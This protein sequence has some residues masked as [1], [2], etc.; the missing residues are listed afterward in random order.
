[1]ASSWSGTVKYPNYRG[2]QKGKGEKNKRKSKLAK[3]RKADA[4]IAQL[5]KL[6]SERQKNLEKAR[7]LKEAKEWET[8]YDYL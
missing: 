7:Y 3:Q 1:M 8:R 4:I 5:R 2:V 6:Q